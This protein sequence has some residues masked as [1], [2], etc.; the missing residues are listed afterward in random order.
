[1]KV[2]VGDVDLSLFLPS[3]KWDYLYSPAIGEVTAELTFDYC[4][5]PLE[6]K[7]P[8]FDP[9]VNKLTMHFQIDNDERPLFDEDELRRNVAFLAGI[10]SK[11]LPPQQRAVLLQRGP[12]L[13]QRVEIGRGK[14]T[15][16][17]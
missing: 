2:R 12:G 3:G 4:K 7:E 17:S 10:I 15:L 8:I 5:T 14:S 1:M 13:A 9:H 16:R 11:R 6:Y